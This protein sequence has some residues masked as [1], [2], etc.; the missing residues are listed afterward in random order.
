MSTGISKSPK[1][2]KFSTTLG[3]TNKTAQLSLNLEPYN[4]RH[5]A[6]PMGDSGTEAK[7]IVDGT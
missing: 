1:E 2:N 4:A 5:Q 3:R 7:G 6:N